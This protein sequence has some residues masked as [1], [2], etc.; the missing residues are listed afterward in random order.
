MLVANAF[1]LIYTTVLVPVQICLWNYDDP[2]NKFPT[3]YFDVIVDSFFMVDFDH[4]KY[5]FSDQLLA[6]ILAQRFPRSLFPRSSLP[7]AFPLSGQHIASAA[8]S[9]SNCKRDEQVDVIIQFFVGV[10]TEEMVYVDNWRLVAA[11]LCLSP[12]G[13]WFDCVTSIPWS[14]M[15]L[16]AYR[17]SAP[18]RK[19]P[20]TKT[21]K[22]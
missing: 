21:E 4:M 19:K 1:F 20:G 15:D 2:C 17:V 7:L 3:L 12:T 8:L 11:K 10:Y 14:F 5:D 9:T 6:N 13:I 16:H 22:I 18:L